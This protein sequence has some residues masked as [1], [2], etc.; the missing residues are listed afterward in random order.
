MAARGKR[1][2]LAQ[3]TQLFNQSVAVERGG[4]A[5]EHRGVD[6]GLGHGVTDPG[7][8]R[9]GIKGA[10]V[11][12]PAGLGVG[13]TEIPVEGGAAAGGGGA[14]GEEVLPFGLHCPTALGAEGGRKR[15]GGCGD[16]VAQPRDAQAGRSRLPLQHTP[17]VKPFEQLP[18][19]SF[20]HM[21]S[22]SK[23][24]GI[25]HK[26]GLPVGQ[27]GAQEFAGEGVIPGDGA[28]V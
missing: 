14:V 25:E 19:G 6:A 13:F 18:D 12:D 17:A 21:Q 15:Q 1:M 26:R 11:A 9:L 16:A 8:N 27:E 4:L 20:G 2:L 5:D 10:P 3:C 7:P 22:G 28:E 23:V 24:A